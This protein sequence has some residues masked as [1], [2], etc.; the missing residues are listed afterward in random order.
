MEDYDLSRIFDNIGH[1]LQHLNLSSL[2]YLKGYES[3]GKSITEKL[4][5]L[6][7]LGLGF[8]L[9]NKSECLTELAHLKTLFLISSR[10]DR[11]INSLLR[12]LSN[13]GIIEKLYIHGCFK[14]EAENATPLNFNKLQ[15][16]D[17]FYINGLCSLLKA[18]TKSQMPAIQ[19]LDIC[20]PGE[21]ELHEHDLLCFVLSKNTLKSIHIALA[22]KKYILSLAFLRQIIEI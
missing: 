10:F 16:I 2:Q 8:K 5:K 19:S 9:T 12:T 14:D 20:A 7:N 11:N 15:T 3:V 17:L 22:D 1:C 18:M 13:N 4:T 6:D 21:D